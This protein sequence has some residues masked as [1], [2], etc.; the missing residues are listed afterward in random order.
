MLITRVFAL[1]QGFDDLRAEAAEEGFNHIETLW[2]QWQDGSNRFDRPGEMLV[3]AVADGELAGIGGITTDFVDPAGLRMRRFYVRPAYRRRGVAGAMATFVLDAA[4]PL[5]R[6]IALLTDTTEG[7]AFWEAMG[8]VRVDGE[9]V[10]HVMRVDQPRPRGS[11]SS[12]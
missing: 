11:A 12:P 3:T 1:P 9:K 7:A 6:P 4:K 2:T 8:F 5:G 10:T